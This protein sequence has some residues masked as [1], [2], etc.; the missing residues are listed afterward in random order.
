[1][2]LELL[3]GVEEWLLEVST[4]LLLLELLVTALVVLDDDTRVLLEDEAGLLLDVEAECTLKGVL[5]LD[6]EL[7]VG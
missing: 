6:M 3:D 2:L 4:D 5:E 1:M 7:I